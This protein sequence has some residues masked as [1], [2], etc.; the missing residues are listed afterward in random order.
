MPFILPVPSR[1]LACRLRNVV[2][3]RLLGLLSA[4]VDYRPV[5]GDI[6]SFVLVVVLLD[7]LLNHAMY[8][9]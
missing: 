5:K 9:V 3:S 8:L 6:V 1:R 7:L 4:Y 2:L